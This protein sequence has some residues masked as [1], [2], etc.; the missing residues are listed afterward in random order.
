MENFQYCCIFWTWN[1]QGLYRC[2]HV[3]KWLIITIKECHVKIYFRHKWRSDRAKFYIIFIISNGCY[4]LSSATWLKISLSLHDSPSCVVSYSCHQL[5]GACRTWLIAIGHTPFIPICTVNFYCEPR[6]MLWG[7]SIIFDDRVQQHFYVFLDGK[8]RLGWG[9]ETIGRVHGM[10][11]TLYDGINCDQV[12][13]NAWSAHVCYFMNETKKWHF[14]DKLLDILELTDINQENIPNAMLVYSHTQLK[15][16]RRLTQHL[17]HDSPLKQVKITSATVGLSKILTRIINKEEQWL[18]YYLRVAMNR[19]S[20][21]FC[22]IRG[23]TKFSHHVCWIQ[24][25]NNAKL[26]ST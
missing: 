16:T 17:R 21:L 25:E 8:F 15:K 2:H 23:S 10:S 9:Y 13:V 1:I 18:E 6:W 26:S 11:S 4:I 7:M 14:D 12:W 3:K 5:M 20:K 22:L 24:M 19:L